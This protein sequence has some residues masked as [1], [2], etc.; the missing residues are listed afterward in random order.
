MKGNLT[1]YRREIHA[2][3]DLRMRAVDTQTGKVLWEER[4]WESR[5]WETEWQTFS[6][7]N[8]ALNGQTPKSADPF[9]PSRASLY[10]S[11][12]D[13]LAGEET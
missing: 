12:R 5:N 7:N 9:S 1:T 13:E 8:R 4:I 2:G 6:G 10:D 3:L 11:M